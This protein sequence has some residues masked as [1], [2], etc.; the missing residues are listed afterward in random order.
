M[1]QFSL[2][3][4]AE[5]LS[6]GVL[7]GDAALIG[8]ATD[9][10]QVKP[11]NLFVAWRGENCDGHDFVREAAKNGAA[12][13]LTEKQVDSPL[14]CLIVPDSLKAMGEL[15][16]Y[17]RNQFDIPF[18]AV[19]GSNGKT[20]I[21]NMLAAIFTEHFHDA[22]QCLV[23]ESSFNNH[24]GLPLT[25]FQLNDQHQVVITEMGMNHFGE[26][27]YLTHIARPDIVLINNAFPCHLAGVGGTLEGVAKAKG[28]IF[29]GLK[30]SGIAVLNADSEFYHYWKKLAK[31]HQQLSFGVEHDA[32]IMA[33]DIQL[34]GDH[35]EF[36][37]KTPHGDIDIHLP[38]LG[39][40]NVMNALA[41]AAVSVAAKVDLQTIKQGLETFK[42]TDR[43]LQIHYLKNGVTLIDD[44]YNANPASTR[45][46][47]DV[48]KQ[49]PGEKVFVFGD[50]KE[51]GDDEKK[52]HQEIG[53][54]AKNAGVHHLL[55]LGDLAKETTHAF[56]EGARH[57]ENQEALFEDLKPLLKKESVVLVK[58]S[59]SMNMKWFVDQLIR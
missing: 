2:K 33:R 59:N 23:N 19:T 37:L 18:I 35:A 29:E 50:M 56:G 14:P 41:A 45:A 1:I 11:N 51:L 40:H 57:F 25:L 6:D 27:S 55:A 47:I 10:R 13:L 46:A 43:L 16:S 15:A 4:F 32:D 8:L 36:I 26:I 5:I 21:K 12:A 39:Q 3:Q 54:Y 7:H 34:L 53:V 30:T 42:T 48:L 20:T 49:M 28:E 22:K 31:K 58:G 17:Y 9:S 38:L 44:A 24:V 52:F